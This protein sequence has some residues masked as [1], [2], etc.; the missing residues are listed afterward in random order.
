MLS[1]FFCSY[2]WFGVTG[3]M[4]A[5]ETTIGQTKNQCCIHHKLLRSR[6]KAPS[7]LTWT[8][9]TLLRR[10]L[11]LVDPLSLL[12]LCVIALT[13]CDPLYNRAQRDKGTLHNIS[14]YNFIIAPVIH[15]LTSTRDKTYCKRMQGRR[16][17][18]TLET[19]AKTTAWKTARVTP[20]YKKGSEQIKMTDS[21][22][23]AQTWSLSCLKD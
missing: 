7:I 20:I 12:N 4:F 9:M 2:R 1:L 21:F 18:K 23:S 17:T 14:N 19:G 3:R 5:L 13:L 11:S 16:I 8:C 22:L 15:A 10:E 6:T